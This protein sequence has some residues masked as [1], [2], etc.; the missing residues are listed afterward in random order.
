[1]FWNDYEPN[2]MA[3]SYWKILQKE[4]N[5]WKLFCVVTN[6]P[7]QIVN[8]SIQEQTIFFSPNFILFSSYIYF[9][10]RIWQIEDDLNHAFKWSF[11]M[12]KKILLRI[13]NF[14]REFYFY[15]S[16]SPTWEL[17]NAVWISFPRDWI[18][19]NIKTI[20]KIVFGTHV[21]LITVK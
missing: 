20:L 5:H 10:F 8:L 21:I 17:T 1:M 15:Q 6:S 9:S 14:V 3:N 4:K 16:T 2:E 12:K 13:L 7:R 18:R 11:W 19:F